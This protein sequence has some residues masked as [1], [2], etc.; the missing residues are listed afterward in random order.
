MQQ[1]KIHKIEQ[2]ELLEV[3][4]PFLCNQSSEVIKRKI[5]LEVGEII[6]IRFPYAWHFRTIDNVYLQAD[7]DVLAVNT[8]AYGRVWENVAFRNQCNL[9]IIL[10]NNLYEKY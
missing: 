1:E 3:V 4:T 6:E 9:K 8:K 2:R 10:D 5:Q 7:E